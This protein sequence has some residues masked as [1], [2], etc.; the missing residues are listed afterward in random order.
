RIRRPGATLRDPEEDPNLSQASCQGSLQIALGGN[1]GASHTCSPKDKKVSS[2]RGRVA[3]STVSK[4]N[5]KYLHGT[6][7]HHGLVP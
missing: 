6:A 5:S 2:R 4:F 7:P 1:R 3:D